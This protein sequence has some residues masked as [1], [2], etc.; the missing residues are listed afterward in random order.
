MKFLIS[1]GQA[2]RSVLGL[3]RV[4]HF[5][6]CLLR[7]SVEVDIDDERSA[8]TH[9]RTERHPASTRSAKRSEPQQERS[10]RGG[11]HTRAG[12][13]EADGEDKAGS[14]DEEVA[15]GVAQDQ[16]PQ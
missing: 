4:N 16:I 11:E 7:M 8:T 13:L 10:D 14:V 2:I 5:T 3:S 1:H 9:E 15:A 6:A 12:V